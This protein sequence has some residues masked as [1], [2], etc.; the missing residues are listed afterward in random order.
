M[1]SGATRV[2]AVIGSPVAHSLSPALHNAA[3]DSLGLDW[4]YVALEVDAGD[5]PRA[6]DA[7]AS[8][9]LSG[10]SVTMPHKESVAEHLARIGRLDPSAAALRSV[11]TVVRAADGVLEGYS[12]DGAGFVASLRAAGVE[13]CGRSVVLVG[14][15]PVMDSADGERWQ[16][17][18]ARTAHVVSVAAFTNG[19][20]SQSAFVLPLD[21]DHERDGSVI[22]LEGRVQRV[23]PSLEPIAGIPLIAWTSRLA[24]FL[25]IEAEG[26]QIGRAHV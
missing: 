14:A 17:A 13:P 4:V 11:N 3:F 26:N 20:T 19:V 5:A 15:D 12:T 23:R 22:N 24:G 6:I 1:I 25:Q 7:M 9:H 18:L 10:L 2:A 8:L 21:V 16:M